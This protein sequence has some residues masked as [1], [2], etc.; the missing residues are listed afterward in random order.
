M[1]FEK[2]NLFY[3]NNSKN[4]LVGLGNLGNTCY[5]NTALQCLSNCFELRKFF[6]DGVYLNQINEGN[7]LGTKGNLA[8]GFCFLMKKLWY[9]ESQNYSPN[10]FK[11]IIGQVFSQVKN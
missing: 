8:D 9:G 11:N 6:L 10:Y 4:G 2:H 3:T 1:K 7:L 5:M